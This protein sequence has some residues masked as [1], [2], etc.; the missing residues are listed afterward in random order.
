MRSH[1]VAVEAFRSGLST[2]SH[3]LL[4]GGSLQCPASSTR[5]AA[6]PDPPPNRPHPEIVGPL[7]DFLAENP[8]YRQYLSYTP[9]R[10]GWAM[11]GWVANALVRW[12]R[13]RLRPSPEQ[14]T[15]DERAAREGRN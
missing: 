12:Q 3:R 10:G 11:P 6:M 7:A 4:I 15:P 13:A 5:G 8:E 2:P 9:E 14:E 1:S